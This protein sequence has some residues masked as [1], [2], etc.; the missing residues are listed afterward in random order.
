MEDNSG[1]GGFKRYSA[2]EA[3]D[4]ELSQPTYISRWRIFSPASFI[5]SFE[6][7]DYGPTLIF[8]VEG[9]ICTVP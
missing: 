3:Y 6:S 9:P 7:N 2:G 4:I 5:Q 8:L 1:D